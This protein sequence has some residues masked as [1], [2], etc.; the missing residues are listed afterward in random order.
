MV[1]TQDVTSHLTSVH[2]KMEQLSGMIVLLNT[3]HLIKIS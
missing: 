1:S 3:K 2:V